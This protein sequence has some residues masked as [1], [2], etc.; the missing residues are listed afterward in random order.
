[1]DR[2]QLIDCAHAALGSLFDGCAHTITHPAGWQRPRNWP[3]PIAATEPAADGTLTRS[4][5]PI[6]VLEWINEQ[7]QNEAA[8]ERMRAQ[9]A[10]QV[11]PDLP[12]LPSLPALPPL[13]VLK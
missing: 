5:R 10:A 4:Y 2:E 3:L 9:Q 12:P 13:P 8:A 1:M 7:V 6:A 11:L